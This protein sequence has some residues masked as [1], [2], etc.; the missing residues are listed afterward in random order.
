[1]EGERDRD[2]GGASL[3]RRGND[4]IGI[5][6]DR[7]PHA[8]LDNTSGESSGIG[9]DYI[10]RPRFY[11][12]LKHEHKTRGGRPRVLCECFMRGAIPDK[13]KAEVCN[14]LILFTPDQPF[15]TCR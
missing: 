9:R 4:G 10:L 3:S 13:T 12:E 6:S 1:M 5:G 8:P 7:H 14:P 2:A 15:V 11:Q